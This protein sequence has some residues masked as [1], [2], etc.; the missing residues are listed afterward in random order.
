[1]LNL[2][3]INSGGSYQDVSL[4][5]VQAYQLAYMEAEQRLT[6]YMNYMEVLEGLQRH[7]SNECLAFASELLGVSAC[8]IS[9]FSQEEYEQRISMESTGVWGAFVK[10]WDGFVKWITGLW[11]RIKDF[12]SSKKS[13]ATD[14]ATAAGSTSATASAKKEGNAPAAQAAAPAAQ[15]KKAAAKKT[16]LPTNEVKAGTHGDYNVVATHTT[17]SI[18]NLTEVCNSV[19]A[20]F[21]NWGK[22]TMAEKTIQQST[23]KLTATLRKFGDEQRTRSYALTGYNAKGYIACLERSLGALNR[24]VHTVSNLDGKDVRGNVSKLVVGAGQAVRKAATKYITIINRDFKYYS[25]KQRS[26]DTTVRSWAYGNMK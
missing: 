12:F 20:E 16:E 7:S 22:K 2:G 24:L 8:D 1:M 25:D 11:K 4:E 9:G 3:I 21:T 26:N 23:A 10:M 6:D 19:N 15:A 14:G 13:S 18:N 5:E 17:E